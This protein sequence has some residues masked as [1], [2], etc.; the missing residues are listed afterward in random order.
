MYSSCILNFKFSDFNKFKQN[1]WRT[2]CYCD[3]HVAHVFEKYAQRSA[4]KYKYS[5]V[6]WGSMNE[7]RLD[8]V[9]FSFT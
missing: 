2:K 9:H 6:I 5:L 4:N 3:T 8:C 7:I 1:N